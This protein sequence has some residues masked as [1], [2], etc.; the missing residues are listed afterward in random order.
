MGYPDELLKTADALLGMQPVTQA[1]LRR[2]VSTAYYALFHLLIESACQSWVQPDYR[3]R[4]AR[5]F[6]H[7]RMKDASAAAAKLNADGQFAA[8]KGIVFL[9]NTFVQCQQSRREADYNLDTT[10]SQ[11]EASLDVLHVKEAFKIWD[12]IKNEN[13]AHDYLFSLLFK[14]R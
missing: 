13:P 12:E 9:A 10:I 4:L 6:D 14:D 2:G 1:N 5:Q 11:E 8:H 7:K 3:K